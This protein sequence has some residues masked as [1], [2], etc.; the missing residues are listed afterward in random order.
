MLNHAG[1]E[2]VG[3]LLS[4]GQV[5]SR[6][7]VRWDVVGPD[8]ASNG[9]GGWEMALTA[10]QAIP[11]GAP[12]LLS[13]REGSNDEFLLNYGESAVCAAVKAA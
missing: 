9:T 5:V 11:A 13:Y 7:N 12:L 2:A 4:S 6:D 10:T 1:D 3:G 8:N